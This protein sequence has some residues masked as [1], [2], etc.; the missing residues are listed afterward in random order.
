MK[1]LILILFVHIILTGCKSYLY[2]KAYKSIGAF[3][4][5]VQL[6]NLERADKKVAFLPMVHVSTKLYYQDVKNKIDSL[7]KDGYYFYY[8]LVN[9]N[10]KD[11]S[12]QR[13][14]RKMLNLPF[15]SKRDYLNVIDSLMKVKNIQLAKKLVNQPKYKELGLNEINSK[16][17]DSSFEDMVAHYEGLYGCIVL[18]PCDFEN[19]YDE[20]SKCENKDF[21]KK[22]SESIVL[23]FRNG[24][25]VNEILN[26]SKHNKIAIIYGRAH[27]KGIKEAL[28]ENGYIE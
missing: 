25:V 14:M 8:E 5:E 16:N 24:V 26:D 10:N 13:K 15:G 21:D 23:D 27:I 20:K 2:N 7:E 6:I 22:K 1:K 12:L 11:D 3:D 9:N 19:N 18:T 28:L 17:V 4:E